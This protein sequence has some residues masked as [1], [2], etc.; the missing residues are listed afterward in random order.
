MYLQIKN[1]SFECQK[2]NKK[3][4]HPQL[5]VCQKCRSNVLPTADWGKVSQKT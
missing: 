4:W 5:I 2:N 1:N 3:N